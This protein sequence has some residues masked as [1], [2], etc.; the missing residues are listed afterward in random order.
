MD[1][2]VGRDGHKT[3]AVL[4]VHRVYLLEGQQRLLSG[5]VCRRVHQLEDVRHS[6]GSF[7]FNFH[8]FEFAFGYASLISFL[9]FFVLNEVLSHYATDLFEV[10][11]HGEPWVLSFVRFVRRRY[12]VFISAVLVKSGLWQGTEDILSDWTRTF[13]YRLAMD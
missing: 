3:L 10:F 5:E 1:F 4:S 12:I 13:K 6:T 11:K 2:A 7:F 8:L 9:E